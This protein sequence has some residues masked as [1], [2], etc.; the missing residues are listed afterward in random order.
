MLVIESVQRL[1][2]LS[3]QSFAFSPGVFRRLL[4]EGI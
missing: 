2:I 1:L 3:E 4:K